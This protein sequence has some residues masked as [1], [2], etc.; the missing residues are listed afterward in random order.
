LNNGAMDFSFMREVLAYEVF[1][2]AAVPA[3]RTAYAKVFITVPGK[4]DRAYAGLYTL[5]ENVDDGFLKR[6]FGTKKGLLL[7]PE[8][9]GG[10]P[11]LGES[12]DAYQNAHEPKSDEMKGADKSR[13]IALTK[14]VNRSDDAA[15]REQI[16]SFMDVDEFLRFLAVNAATANL[17]SFL[18]MGHNYYLF[19]HPETQK[20]TWIPWDLNEAFGRFMMGGAPVHQI[21]LSID[22]PHAGENKLIERLLA[23]PEQQAYRK[24][25][26]QLAASFRSGQVRANLDALI[27]TLRPL[28]AY[29]PGVAVEQFETSV[30]RSSTN[31]I[32]G[33]F[34]SPRPDEAS[35]SDRVPGGFGSRR[36][37]GPP[38]QMWLVQRAESITEQLAGKREGVRPRGGPRSM[39]GP[40][41]PG[42]FR[43]G[44][45]GP[46]Q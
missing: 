11:Y 35:R 16:G 28:V 24:H 43:P 34:E 19:L 39:G 9:R 29:E 7:K 5:V 40:Q 38:L 4:Y 41:G 27:L 13:F 17:D 2:E 10:L 18:S 22:Q 23:V 33:R 45:F 44:G 8:A 31:R 37:I 30:W 6:H 32:A 46:P 1:R 15:F 25:L 14:L 3:P 12:W 36:P 20:V 21:D 42:G 26:E